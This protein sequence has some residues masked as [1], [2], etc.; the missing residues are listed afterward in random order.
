MFQILG[1]CLD[2]GPLRR[3]LNFLQAATLL[4]LPVTLQDDT[5]GEP[6]ALPLSGGMAARASLHACIAIRPFKT[7]IREQD[8]IPPFQSLLQQHIQV[9]ASAVLPQLMGPL[10][11]HA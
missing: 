10:C 4:M 5:P 2:R 6:S 11:S 3:P 8:D 7:S 9:S 1:L